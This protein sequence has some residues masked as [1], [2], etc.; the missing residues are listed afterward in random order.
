MHLV[1]LTNQVVSIADQQF[2][3]TKGESIHTENSYKF[4]VEE[5]EELAESG[6]FKMIKLWTDINQFFS[7]CYLLAD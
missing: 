7:V 5:I 3:F 6:G 1:S 2:E 4:T